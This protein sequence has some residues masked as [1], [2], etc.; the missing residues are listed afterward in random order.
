MA[1]QP[2]AMPL[3]AG[4]T[5][6]HWRMDAAAPFSHV[7]VSV[8]ELTD[9]NGSP[10]AATRSKIIDHLD[11]HCRALIARSP[12]V[13]LG[14]ADRT[15]CADVSPR[16]GPPG[17]VEVLDE[18]RLVLADAK[19]NRLM[20]SLRNI[21]ETGQAG[22][23]FLLPGLSETLRVNGR[24]WVTRD[25][26]LLARHEVQPGR[27]PAVAVGIEVTEAYLH[28]AKALIRSSLWDPSTWPSL[29][30]LA[31]PA[32]IWRDHMALPDVSVEDVEALIE[33]EYVHELY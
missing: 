20:D 1:P 32:R 12:L 11:E 14:T 21:L 16:G 25:P 9:A 26:E 17:F 15:G 18:R 23:L 30:G 31:R 29:E 3:P 19:G 6:D 2:G 28:C 22:L 7:V 24:A 4:P 8:D 27:T 13:L 33:Q 5:C 10:E